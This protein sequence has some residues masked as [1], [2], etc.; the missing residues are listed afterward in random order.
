MI[1][2]CD[3]VGLDVVPAEE[4][5]SFLPVHC[6]MFATVGAQIMELVWLE[7]VAAEELWEFAF[8]GGPLKLTGATGS[9]LRPMAIALR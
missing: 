8:I 3:T 9:P 1:I 2:G 6:Y 4:P 5:D 7:E